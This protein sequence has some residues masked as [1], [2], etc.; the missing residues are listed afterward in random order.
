MARGAL[1][2]VLKDGRVL[3]PYRSA[4]NPLA[5]FDAAWTGNVSMVEML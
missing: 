1:L 2:S 5:A 4:G 3:V